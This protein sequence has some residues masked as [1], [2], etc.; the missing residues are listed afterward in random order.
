VPDPFLSDSDRAKLGGRAGG[1]TRFAMEIVVDVARMTGAERL[2]D[3]ASAHI[4]GCLYHGQVSVDF[5]R[6]LV[7]GGARVAVPATLNVSSLDLLHPELYRGD[8]RTAAEARKLMDLYVAMG[9]HPTWTCAPYQVVSSGAGRGWLPARPGLGE[10]VAWAESNAVVFANSVLG[11]RTERYGDFIDICAAVTGRVPDAGLH[12]HENRRGRVLFRLHRVGERLLSQDVLYPVLGHLVGLAAGSRVPVID[13]LPPT[14]SEDQL[15]ALGAG[16][17]SSGAVALFHVVGVT[18]EA[19][20]VEAALHD[21]PPE[22]VVDVTPERLARARDALSTAGDDSRLAAVSVGTP[23]FSV[24]EFARLTALLDGV[25]VHPDVEFY[26]NTGRG[27]LEEVEARGWL[28]VYP[29]AGVSIVTDT[30]TYIT[31]ILRA[32]RVG[33]GAARAGMMGSGAARA[34]GG[35]AMTNSAKW[36]YYAPGNLGVEVVFGSLEECVRS[37][38]LGKVWRDRSLWGNL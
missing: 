18:P 22:E 35:T 16:A 32:G 36:A 4:D 2:I 11:A 34:G 10:H 25:R 27:V 9:C 20:T 31:P 38:V 30:C 37:A 14:A 21:R 15:K 33:S 13:G 17:A 7:D 3:V 12:R 26:V 29:R 1:A 6:R 23:H 19:P 8:P 24:E 5:A 28:P